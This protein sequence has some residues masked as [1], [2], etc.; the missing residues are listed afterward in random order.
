MMAVRRES[1]RSVLFQILLLSFLFKLKIY[2]TL[3]D[4][5]MLNYFSTNP[6]ELRKPFQDEIP[7]ICS[8][9]PRLKGRHAILDLPAY[10]EE[11]TSLRDSAILLNPY[12]AFN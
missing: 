9:T 11:D 4:L 8:V 2:L 10:V 5:S 3:D 7:Q 1:F 6:A 12:P